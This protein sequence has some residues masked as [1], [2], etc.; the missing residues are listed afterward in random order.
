MNCNGW[1]LN[2]NFAIDFYSLENGDETIELAWSDLSCFA[3]GVKQEREREFN[4]L[5]IVLG[6]LQSDRYCLD[7]HDY[8][9][10]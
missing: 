4:L 2:L 1:L 3:S 7:K 8:Q 10:K 9:Y 5:Y 6:N